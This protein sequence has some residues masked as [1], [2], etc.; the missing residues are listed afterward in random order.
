MGS[1]E[2][3]VALSHEVFNWPEFQALIRRLGVP[4]EKSIVGISIN[5]NVGETAKYTV[6]CRGEDV[7]ETTDLGNQVFRTFAPKREG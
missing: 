2:A 4:V 5:L 6:Q 7:V 1:N 3:K